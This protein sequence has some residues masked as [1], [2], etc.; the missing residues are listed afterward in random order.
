M[1]LSTTIA[2]AEAAL[3]QFFDAM[4]TWENKYYALAKTL[5]GTGV[6]L[7]EYMEQAREEL[8]TIFAAHC[9]PDKTDMSRLITPRLNSPTL[10]NR[11]HALLYESNSGKDCVTFVYQQNEGTEDR[12]RFTLRQT[13][14][15]WRIAKAEYFDVERDDWR[16]YT[17]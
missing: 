12:L 4:C 17:L 14:D 16:P 5:G 10:Y 2:E 8:R 7:D 3:V 1:M 15:D 9:M 6:N 13:G 11:R